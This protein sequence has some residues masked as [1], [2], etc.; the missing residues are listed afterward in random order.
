MFG[1]CPFS[2]LNLRINLACRILGKRASLARKNYTP[3]GLF[4]VIW[5]FHPCRNYRIFCLLLPLS[6]ISIWPVFILLGQTE[7]K[8]CMSYLIKLWKKLLK[9]KNCFD[10]AIIVKLVYKVKEQLLYQQIHS[11][12]LLND[13][14]A[15][16]IHVAINFL[17]FSSSELCQTSSPDF[18][19]LNSLV[20]RNSRASHRITTKG[21]KRLYGDINSVSEVE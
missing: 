2:P 21:F 7:K 14:F 19:K 10:W 18:I 16:V 17:D 8:N 6:E 3:Y 13:H 12:K 11:S 5:P 1:P 15:V 9:T 4:L 20:R